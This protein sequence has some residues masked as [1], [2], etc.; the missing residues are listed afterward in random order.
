MVRKC[1]RV[2]AISFSIIAAVQALVAQT[3]GAS[4]DQPYAG[5]RNVTGKGIPGSGPLIAYEL[6]GSS[7]NYLGRSNSIDQQ[8]IYAI[9][10]SPPLVNGQKIVVID[11]QNRSS[12]IVTVILKTGPAGPA[13]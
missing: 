3:P 7:R 11:S 5:D 2:L 6:N 13:N 10:V 4:V 12:S 9:A 8:G 1:I